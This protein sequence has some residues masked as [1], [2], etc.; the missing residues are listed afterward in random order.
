MTSPN[1]S[2]MFTPFLPSTFNLPE[3]EDRVKTWLS[4]KFSQVSDVVNDK[5]I[6]IVTQSAESFS[7]GKPFYR[8]TQVQRNEYQTLVYIP[9]LPNT[10]TLTISLTGF[11]LY[12]IAN[13]NPELVVTNLYGTASKPPTS[14][15]AGD[16]DYIG[17]MNEGNSKISFTMSDIAIVITTTTDLSGYVG[18]IF[19]NYVRNGL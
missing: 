6:G 19:I 7:G 3:E 12:P 18:L 13:V 1:P 5:R 15:G 2:E 8:S 14:V 10:T 9:S 11:P 17:F 4:E 16:G